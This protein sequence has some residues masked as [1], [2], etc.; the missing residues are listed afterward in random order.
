M[1][2]NRPKKRTLVRWDENLDE[3]LL[4]TIQSVCNTQSV[5]IPW[6]NV[7][8]TMGN[9]VTEGA[10][11]QHLAKLRTRRAAAGKDVPP[12]LK[13]G[14]TGGS[15]KFSE[16]VA[17]R[18]KKHTTPK[19]L[20]DNAS[21]SDEE[22]QEHRTPARYDSS[23]KR[24]KIEYQD[25]EAAG[26]EPEYDS[27]ESDESIEELLVPGAKFLEFLD[28]P[29]HKTQ[30][31]ASSRS[32]SPEGQKS[33]VIVLKYR[34]PLVR[35]CDEVPQI[36][37]KTEAKEANIYETL[38]NQLPCQYAPTDGGLSFRQN[39]MGVSNLTASH[40]TSGN[41]IPFPDPSKDQLGN[42]CD[43][44]PFG[45]TSAD[46]IQESRDLRGYV[47]R[48]YTVTRRKLPAWSV[49]YDD[50]MFQAAVLSELLLP[51]SPPIDH[52]PPNAIY[53]PYTLGFL[54]LRTR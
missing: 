13:R 54:T 10:I 19:R 51:F 36:T 17:A 38:T 8:K 16:V 24:R 44:V 50:L 4:L 25:I 26:L 12:P 42:L 5:K 30:G 34:K 11:V 27:D 20:V 37:R 3:L 52:F 21:A 9:N 48:H 35:T 6:S 14:S 28:F 47:C 7:A 29:T 31:T 45:L 32:A 43:S 15:G 53:D 1:P 41:Y 18:V 22:W 39:A 23:L 40:E 33:N 49:S 46:P 2:S